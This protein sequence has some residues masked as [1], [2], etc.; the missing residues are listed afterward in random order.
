LETPSVRRGEY[1]RSLSIDGESHHIGRR[2]PAHFCPAL[3]TAVS[4]DWHK[5]SVW[6]SNVASRQLQI[7]QR[8]HV[9][10]TVSVLRDAHAPSHDGVSCSAKSF[11]EAI[12][13]GTSQTCATL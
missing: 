4:T 7:H 11:G 5:A 13:I 9:V 10:T 2:S 8:A 3:H 12:H 6:T 1:L